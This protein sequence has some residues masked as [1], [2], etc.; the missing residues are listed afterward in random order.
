MN[1]YKKGYRDHSGRTKDAAPLKDALNR[2]FQ[3]YRLS[4]KFNET[5][6]VSSW[7]SIMGKPIASRTDKI[8]IKDKIL[9][10]KLSSAPLKNELLM[11]KN[12]IMEL[13]EKEGAKGIIEDI[14]F[15]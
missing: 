1:K 7:E 12:K 6:V 11:S 13:L 10:V 8:Y 5:K 14:R 4:R 3:E 15:L 2:M 9:F